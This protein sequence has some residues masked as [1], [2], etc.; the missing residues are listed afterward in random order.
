MQ[1]T[2][3]ALF[4][5]VLLVGCTSAADLAL[6]ALQQEALGEHFSTSVETQ[7]GLAGLGFLGAYGELTL[8]DYSY[9]PPTPQ[10]GMVGTLTRTGPFAFGTGTMT[11]MFTTTADGV[12][13]DPF[14]PS[15][16]MASYSQVDIDVQTDFDGE[17]LGGEPLQALADFDV[18]TIP[19]GTDISVATITGE[20]DVLHDGH[21]SKIDVDGLQLTIDR[22]LGEITDVQGDL[23]GL[24]QIP[25][26]AADAFFTAEGLGDQIAVDIQAAVTDLQL[27]LD[28]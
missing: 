4:L 9:D 2:A 1:K 17:N 20:F 19:D 6:S 8:A 27:L 28:L 11:I 7:Q 25:D 15:V 18:S 26:F 16:D 22:N 5:C 21:A 3:C 13:I 12:P 23:T 10:N 14:A 24:I